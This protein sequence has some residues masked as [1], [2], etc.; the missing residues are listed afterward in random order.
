[1]ANA[2]IAS[3]IPCCLACS[4]KISGPTESR[5]K[6]YSTISLILLIFTSRTPGHPSPS[7]RPAKEGSQETKNLYTFL[8]FP[9]FHD[10]ER[11]LSHNYDTL[12]KSNILCATTNSKDSL[13]LL[14]Y[15]PS[16]YAFPK[17]N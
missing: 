13:S 4:L 15:P 14:K 8:P 3:G 1:M 6:Y 11:E 9:I 10:L 7:T 5:T 16:K 12:S 17:K 2:I